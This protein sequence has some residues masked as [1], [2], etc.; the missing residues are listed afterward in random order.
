MVNSEERYSRQKDII[1]LEKLESLNISII[2]VGAIGRNVALM[3]TSIGANKITLIDFDTVEE[4]NIASQGY[5]ERDIGSTKVEATKR[6]CKEINSEVNITCIN[7]KFKRSLGI[8]DVVFLCVDSITTRKFIWETIK[9]NVQFFVDGRMSAEVFRILTVDN[10][11]SKSYY[12]TTLFTEAEAFGG[13]C[14][15]KSTIYCASTAASQMI[16][17]FT[18]WLREFPCDKDVLFNMLTCEINVE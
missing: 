11:L 8:D 7:D 9:D 15:A 6:S 4:S 10:A 13:S 5:L 1:S 17:S 12:P 16:S 3:L 2:G 14:T 18:K